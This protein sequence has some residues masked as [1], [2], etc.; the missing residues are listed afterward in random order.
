MNLITQLDKCGGPACENAPLGNGYCV[1]HQNLAGKRKAKKTDKISV[2][3]EVEDPNEVN[4][5]IQES[6]IIN[7][8]WNVLVMV[9]KSKPTPIF[10][11]NDEGHLLID[12]TD[13]IKLITADGGGRAYWDRLLIDHLRWIRKTDDGKRNA[14]MPRAISGPALA[15]I[16]RDIPVLSHVADDPVLSPDGYLITREGYHPDTQV[17]M[18][19]SATA[20]DITGL[21]PDPRLACAEVIKSIHA[22]IFGDFPF[23]NNTSIAVLYGAIF[24]GILRPYFSGPSPL[25]LIDASIQGSGKTKLAEIIRIL[26]GGHNA[27]VRYG[28]TRNE[29]E[30]A[31]QITTALLQMP[32]TVL[33]DNIKCR[34]DSPSLAEVLTAGYHQDRLLGGMTEVRI[35]N[36]ALWIATLNNASLDR[37]FTR[38]CLRIRLTP[39]DDKPHL[40]QGFKHSNL[41]DWIKKNRQMIL[42][43]F[44]QVTQLWIIAGRP[45]RVTPLLGSYEDFTAKVGGLLDFAGFH[46]FLSNYE[47][48]ELEA[49]P[50]ERDWITAIVSYAVF[51]Q[52]VPFVAGDFRRWVETKEEFANLHGLD[53]KHVGGQLSA[54]AG[55]IYRDYRLTRVRLNQ[56]N[57]YQLIPVAEN[58]ATHF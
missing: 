57:Q 39:H 27:T 23:A 12:S 20:P 8:L 28:E 13:G 54:R 5:D 51:K 10:Y 25:I 1:L 55:Q 32:A 52:G 43:L 15:I 35:P 30:R 16:P 7:K 37:D 38:R 29:S 44:H 3:A 47:E 18:R 42:H 2:E 4:I 48:L 17:I 58:P 50:E 49:N 46:D 45:E 19:R 56:A 40:R 22:E 9:N 53:N 36:K 6:K 21:D 26:A 41:I 33:M 14:K 31:K 34:I 11:R 24:A